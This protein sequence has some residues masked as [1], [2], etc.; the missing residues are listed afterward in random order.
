MA[1]KDYYK[2]LGVTESAKADEIKKTYR[3]LAKRYHPDANPGD[4]QAAERFKEINEAHET[5]SDARKRQQYDDMRRFGTSGFR[6]FRPGGPGRSGPQGFN[7]DDIFSRFAA[8][9]GGGRRAGATFTA[10]NLGAFGDL[11]DLLSSMFGGGSP[12]AQRFG[13]QKGQD[14][15]AEVEVPFDTAAGGGSTVISLARAGGAG[16]ATETRRLQVKIPRGIADGGKIRLRGQGEPGIAG[17]PPGDLIIKINVRGDSFFRRKGANI[18]CDVKINLTEAVLGGKIKVRTVEGKHAIL[19]IPEGTQPGTTFKLK[20]M[21]IK[22]DGTQGD[23]YVTV[24]VR[25][26]TDLTPEEKKLFEK[27]AENREPEK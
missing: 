1:Y 12:G 13:P 4:N 10:Q 22:K 15:Y 17:G 2:I 6:G 25:I 16:Q 8:G 23:Q 20:G 5:L 7:A 26:P 27:L 18:Y 19:K 14:H 21:G 11:G 24:N 3:K 9:R